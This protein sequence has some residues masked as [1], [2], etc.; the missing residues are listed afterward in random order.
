MNIEQYDFKSKII[1]ANNDMERLF[2]LQ[3]A[4]HNIEIIEA[5]YAELQAE[6]AK[7]IERADKYER[8]LHEN[9]KSHHIY[10]TMMTIVK[11]NE[12]V[13]AAFDDLLAIM[14]LADSEVELKME[15]TSKL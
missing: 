5:R 9:A 12:T 1:Q 13:Q 4:R 2:E 6:L 7:N 3:D 10:T 15:Y 11:D 14:K 8:R